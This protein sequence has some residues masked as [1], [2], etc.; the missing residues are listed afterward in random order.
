MASQG[1]QLPMQ[2]YDDAYSSDDSLDDDPKLD[3]A[4]S[5]RHSVTEAGVNRWSRF[6]AEDLR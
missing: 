1:I 4:D 3:D 5:H 6:P 2:P